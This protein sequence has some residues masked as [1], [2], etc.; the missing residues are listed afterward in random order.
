MQQVYTLPDLTPQV[1]ACGGRPIKLGVIGNPIA[2]SKSPQMQQAGL[3][4]AG[5]PMTY[6]RLLAGTAAGEFEATMQALG[7]RGFIGLNVTIPFKKQA[8]LL[9]QE[10][11]ELTSLCGAGNTLVHLPD[12]GWRLH[13]T[14]GP[15]FAQA[16]QELTGCPLGDLRVLLLGACGGAGC[17]LAAQCALSGCPQITLANRPKPQLTELAE[18][19]RAQTGANIEPLALGSDAMA[20]AVREADLIVNA[21][22]LGLHSGDPLPLSPELLNP[23][24]WVYDIVTHPTPLCAA[25]EEHGCRADYGLSMLLW[26][27]AFAF[28]HWFGTLPNIESMRRALEQ[29]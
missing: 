1:L 16:V 23:G 3:D 22:S 28:R 25:A 24:Q 13:N 17:A 12:G 21:T 2:H 10:K 18:H 26:Q 15:G 7:E 29:A 14:D 8:Y 5:I 27:G 19:L 4:A 11:D 9:A 20:A 6:V